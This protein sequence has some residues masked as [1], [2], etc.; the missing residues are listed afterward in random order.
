MMIMHAFS[1]VLTTPRYTFS[2]MMSMVI[3]LT[4]LFIAVTLTYSLLF[5][6]LPYPNSDRLVKVE[7]AQYD[8]NDQFNVE[9]FNYPSLMALY[10]QRRH[11][12]EVALVHYAEQLLL[13]H[14]DSPKVNTAFVTHEW[15][16]MFDI[17]MHLGRGFT[18]QSDNTLPV[19][20]M[21]FEHWQKYSEQDP[22][23]VGKTISFGK[24]SFQV[25]GVTAAHFNEANLAQFNQKTGVWLAWDHNLTTHRARSFWW[26][27][28]S[29]N[30]MVARLPESE[31]IETVSLNLSQEMNSVWQT[32]VKGETYFDGWHI[33]IWLTPLKA[34]LLGSSRSLVLGV[35]AGAIGLLLMVLF[36]VCNL[37]IAMLA[38]RRHQLVL[39]VALGAKKKQLYAQL[40][41][42]GL[43]IMFTATALA[44][45]IAHLSLLYGAPWLATL[46]PHVSLLTLSWPI[47]VMILASVLLL[48]SVLVSVGLS[49]FPYQ[50]L[51]QAM[52]GATKG[53]GVQVSAQQ[54]NISVVSQLA[55][56]MM[57]VSCLL[58]V[59]WQQWQQIE[60]AH[61]LPL[62]DK[63]IV[64]L[65]DTTGSGEAAQQAAYTHAANVLEALPMVEQVSRSNSPLGE[66]LIT[67][68][69]T[70]V[71][72]LKKVTPLGK[73][74]DYRYA[75]FF[76]QTLLA[77]RFFDVTDVQNNANVLMISESLAKQL[78]GID[79][80]LSTR[81]S[82]NIDD[83]DAAMQIIGVVA[84][85]VSVNGSRTPSFVYRATQGRHY[86][87]VHLVPGH[88]LSKV[89]MEQLFEQHQP[90]MKVF[91]VQSLESQRSALLLANKLL[92]WVSIC[93]TIVTLVLAAVGLFGVMSIR[94]SAQRQTIAMKRAIGAKNSQLVTEMLLQFGRVAA[95]ATLIAVV[96]SILLVNYF[97]TAMD[98]WAASFC[99]AVCVVLINAAFWVYQ[100]LQ[101]QLK[102]A[103]GS[104]LR[105]G[106][107]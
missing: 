65:S 54:I 38:T 67:W 53:V 43:L 7:F 36:N 100:P 48:N 71:D 18:H 76:S 75:T 106:K 47:V 96:G 68:D 107:E 94:Q 28:Y 73:V 99:I 34:V 37:Y 27:R 13:S 21:S 74:V 77:G 98:V 42:E 56:A 95:I 90:G 9:A 62:K 89:K 59:A 58:T 93:I 35:L 46:F 2:V 6:P 24:A 5:S 101:Q 55:I 8:E 22:Q 49:R 61:T 88:S 50:G 20:V 66:Q 32:N 30:L 92:L 51:A 15:F 29:N 103:I 41:C 4:T 105:G 19:A 72:T 81:L 23:I 14:V 11:L 60:L 104:Q 64:Q 52:A 70:L 26:N 84:D 16:S 83:P 31:T 97:T 33:K 78:G 25:I 80:A 87:L 39:R 85:Q 12:E 17:P 1:Q 63:F 86:L 57:I 10:Q 3:A 82:F 79:Q 69:L 102:H 40:W 44:M 91:R 45:I